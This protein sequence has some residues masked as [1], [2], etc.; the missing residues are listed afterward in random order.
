MKFRE[1]ARFLNISETVARSLGKQR[2]LPGSPCADGWETTLD[3]IERWYVNLSGK[4]WANLVADGQVDP[5]IVE[6]DLEGEVTTE[7][8]LTALRS[9][10]QKGMVK[11]ISHNL[12]PPAN[13]EV[14]LTLCEAAEKGRKGIE[15]LEHTALIESVRSQI[16]LTYRCEN[17]IGKNPV[18]VT[19]SKQKILKLGIEDAMAELPQRER[20]I[21]RFHLASYALRLSTELRGE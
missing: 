1:I 2:I 21:I 6:V 13:P 5:L 19:L 14:V 8:L 3:E 4:E 11:I 9:W 16:E 15:S 20:E 7:A 10:E 12:E 18:L 17:I